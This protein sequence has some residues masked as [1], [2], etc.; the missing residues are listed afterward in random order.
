MLHKKIYHSQYCFVSIVW[1]KLFKIFK[2]GRLYFRQW[3][4][5]FFLS[6]RLCDIAEQFVFPLGFFWDDLVFTLFFSFCRTNCLIKM[7]CFVAYVDVRLVPVHWI[8]EVFF[9]LFLSSFS[10]RLTFV[11]KNTCCQY[12]NTLVLL[13]RLMSCKNSYYFK[14]PWQMDGFLSDNLNVIRNIRRPIYFNP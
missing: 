7:S 8:V 3:P 12:I 14:L 2:V 4:M 9:P 11:K 5:M 10:Y 6:Y 1:W 13:N